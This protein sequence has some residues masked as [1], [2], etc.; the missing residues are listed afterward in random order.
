MTDTTIKVVQLSDTHIK[1]EFKADRLSKF[2][3]KINQE[4]PDI[5]VFTG[6]LYDNYAN[7]QSDDAVIQQLAAINAS[8]AK[9]AVWG[10]HD[11]GGG[12]V[13][14]YETIMAAGGFQLLKNE[15]T[16][17]PLENGKQ[18][19]ISGLDDAMLGQSSLPDV[20]EM[21]GADYRILVSHEPDIAAEHVGEGFDLMLAGHS[22]GGQVNLPFFPSINK[23]AVQT[24][25]HAETYS[26]GLYQLGDNGETT[27]YVNRGIGTTH[28]A[29]RFGVVPEIAV[30][31]I[32]I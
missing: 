1:A 31:N 3:A 8:T 7:Y 19:F 5:V 20:S 24:T 29:A 28:V 23:L 32:K 13:R 26:S 12:A 2:V 25:N 10:N 30:F 6:D 22:H 14:Q 16:T 15:N 9:L 27:L 11:Y 18:V 17:L 4:N 21:V